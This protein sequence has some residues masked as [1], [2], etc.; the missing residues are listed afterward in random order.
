MA[1][2]W[3]SEQAMGDYLAQPAFREALKT[4]GMPTPEIETFEIDRSR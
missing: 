4:V 2:V 1:D 3:E